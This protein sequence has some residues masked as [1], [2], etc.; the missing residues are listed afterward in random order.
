MQVK[1]PDA[2]GI[3]ISSREHFVAVPADREKNPVRKFDS[4]TEDLYQLVGWLKQCR[5]K[6]V[7]MESTGV[8]WYH[9]FTIL[10][11]E[12]FEVYLVNAR[13]IKNVPGRK[14]MYRIVNGSSNCT[15]TGC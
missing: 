14:A 11:E 8:Y 9:L 2:A 7:A 13:H 1:N 15:P 5:I 12:G 3:D 10:Q 4:F 6:T